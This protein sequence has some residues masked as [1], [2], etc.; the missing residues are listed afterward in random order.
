MGVVVSIDKPVNTGKET[1][2]GEGTINCIRVARNI[3]PQQPETKMP[4]RAIIIPK[5]LSAGITLVA[6]DEIFDIAKVLAPNI[7]RALVIFTFLS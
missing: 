2:D 1:F 7:T 5:V 6:T 4:A 3:N